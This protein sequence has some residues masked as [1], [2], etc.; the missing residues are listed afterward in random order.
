MALSV[1]DNPAGSSEPPGQAAVLIRLLDQQRAIYVK[2]CELG[3]TQTQLV[4]GG[5]AQPLLHILAQRQNL[6]DRLVEISTSLEPYKNDWSR[7]W[8]AFDAPTQV[9]VGGLIDHVQDLLNQVLQQDRRDRDALMGH[10]DRLAVQM[11]TLRR[12]HSVHRAYGRDDDRP[13]PRYTDQH[14]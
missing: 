12:G 13:E 9:R 1:H 2:L 4:A 3:R 8:S 11:N 14:G 7:V 5:E 10:R 6:I